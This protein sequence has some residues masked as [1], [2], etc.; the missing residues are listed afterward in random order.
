MEVVLPN[1][2]DPDQT[3]D[4]PYVASYLCLHCLPMPLLR[5]SRYQWVKD[6]VKSQG[7]LLL[8]DEL[9]VEWLTVQTLIRQLI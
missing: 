5:V 2:V 8:S 9:K 7:N 3:S 4:H 1:N 6:L